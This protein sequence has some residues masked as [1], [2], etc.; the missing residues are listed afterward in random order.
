M[1]KIYL[2]LL[3]LIISRVSINAQNI[4]GSWGGI[5]KIQE[6]Q[7][8]VVVNL[9]FKDSVYTAT[10]DSPDQNVFGIPVKE[11]SFENSVLKLKIPSMFVE[12]SGVFVIDKFLGSFKQGGQTFALNLSK[13][14]VKEPKRPQTPTAPYP[15]YSENVTFENKSAGATLAGTLTLPS[16]DGKYPVVVLVSGSGQ[17]NRD[18]EIMG[19][20]PFLVLADYLTK[21]GIGV[22]RYDDRGVGESKGSLIGVTTYDF[23]DD[24][25]AAIEYLSQRKDV[26]VIGMIGHSEGGMIAPLAATK[27]DKI[28]FIVMMAGPAVPG[29][30]ILAKQN[31]EIALRSGV[32]SSQVMLFEQ[33]NR[34]LY[35]IVKIAP[36]SSELKS[37][38]KEKLITASKGAV[39]DEV[40]DKQA[41]QLTSS[42]MV[43]FLN[44]NPAKYLSTLKIPILA[45]Y[46][47]NDTQVDSKMNINAVK[48]IFSN[49][50]NMNVT[51][52]NKHVIIAELQGLNHLFQESSS[53]LP[54]EYAS[55]EQTISPKFLVL[56]NEWMKSIKI[57]NN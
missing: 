53:G 50:Y 8:K 35:D 39:S 44:F 48:Q 14:V 4:E 15:Y 30:E 21:N 27:C 3:I 32:D 29:R 26:S 20:K 16:K 38:I 43:G 46:G 19:H 55:I 5:L 13:R 2:F 41:A 34:E 12:Y 47:T 18:S 24:A 7:L 17:Q 25:I 51:T 54:N 45:V 42:W 28:K 33:L 40:A 37:L 22:L 11:V 23:T 52:N 36:K 10:M 57:I 1:K 31:T 9:K 6:N 49:N 56:L